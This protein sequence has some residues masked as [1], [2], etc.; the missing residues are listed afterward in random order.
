MSCFHE[1]TGRVCRPR[2]HSH[3]RSAITDG[4]RDHL[5][6]VA[7]R[8]ASLDFLADG[9][10]CD[11]IQ[12]PADLRRHQAR[13]LFHGLLGFCMPVRLGE[14]T[15]NLAWLRVGTMASRLKLRLKSAVFIEK[16]A[17][18]KLSRAPDIDYLMPF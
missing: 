12:R 5:H 10:S 15:G 1:L 8:F 13:R 17:R 16:S 18:D 7:T 4:Q 9:R 3:R 14:R 2:D 6:T 11:T